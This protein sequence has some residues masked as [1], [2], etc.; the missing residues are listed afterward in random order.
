MSERGIETAVILAGGFGTRLAAVVSDVPKPMAPIAGRPFLERLLDRLASQGIAR[1]VLAV[2]YRSQAIRAHFGAGRA[3]MELHYSEET[4]PL[5]TGGALRRAFESQDLQRAIALNG[6]TW[7]DV[8]LRALART[9]DAAGTVATLTLVHQPDASR[10]GTVEVDA[11]GRV[12]GFREKR[13][14]AGP[15]LIN[16]G[17]YALDRGV[18]DLAPAHAR[19]SFENDVLQARATEGRF[20]AHVA[21]HATFIDIGVPDDYARAQTLLA[22]A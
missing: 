11:H 21:A 20:A 15:G 5:G 19:F 16:A 8:D 6:D 10:F 17:V 7:C 13:P 2:G 22:H 9:H 4:E 18:F 3:G 1:A 14:D 12:A